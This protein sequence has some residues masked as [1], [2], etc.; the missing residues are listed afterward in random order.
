MCSFGCLP[1]TRASA[2]KYKMGKQEK[3][4]NKGPALSVFRM[5]PDSSRNNTEMQKGKT[6]HKE[7]KNVK[8]GHETETRYYKSGARL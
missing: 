1:E 2:N 3:K 6:S 8:R 4:V 5:G 7:M